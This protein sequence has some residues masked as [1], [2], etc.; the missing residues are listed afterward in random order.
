M[1]FTSVVWLLEV[2]KNCRFQLF[3]YFRFWFFAKDLEA[4]N[5]VPDFVKNHKEIVKELAIFGL[6]LVFVF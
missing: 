3:K 5:H 2:L 1:Y 4:K 6:V